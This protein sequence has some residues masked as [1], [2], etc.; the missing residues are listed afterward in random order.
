MQKNLGALDRVAR[1]LGGGGTIVAALVAPWETWL[2]LAVGAT[3]GYV[4]LT[5]FVGSCVGYRLM[6]LSSCPAETR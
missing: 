6:G 4:L 3:G 5:A 1:G 2:R